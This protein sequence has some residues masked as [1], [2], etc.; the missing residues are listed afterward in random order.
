MAIIPTLEITPQKNWKH[1]VHIHIGD[2]LQKI[3]FPVKLPLQYL[4]QNWTCIWIFKY[5]LNKIGRYIIYDIW[6]DEWPKK[7][8]KK[9]NI[10]N[11][12][13]K[14]NLLKVSNQNTKK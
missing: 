6:I 10:N 9:N 14:N 8:T 1:H 2:F 5:K 7:K 12:L 11:K 3:T 13:H 4:S